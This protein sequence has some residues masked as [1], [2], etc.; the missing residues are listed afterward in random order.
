MTIPWK[1]SQRAGVDEILAALPP[2]SHRCDDAARQILP[3]ALEIEPAAGT[4]RVV[5]DPAQ[6]PRGTWVICP[7]QPVGRA[8]YEHWTVGVVAHC[9]DALTRS[10]GCEEGR[11][12]EA[13]WHYPE[14]LVLERKVLPEPAEQA[15]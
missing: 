12:L 6:F 14:A 11:Y 13:H 8:W 4:L 15:P 3:I 10:D 5:A 7:K 2:E 9:V 1:P